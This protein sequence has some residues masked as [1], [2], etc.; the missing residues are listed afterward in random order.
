MRILSLEIMKPLNFKNDQTIENITL[1]LNKLLEKM[2]LKNPHNGFGLIIGGNRSII[3]SFN[4][5]FYI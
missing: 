2:I 5:S 1:K 3:F 4:T